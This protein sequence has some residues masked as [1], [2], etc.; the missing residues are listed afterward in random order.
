MAVWS[1][2]EGRQLVAFSL[3]C[4]LQTI[5]YTPNGLHLVGGTSDGDIYVWDAEEYGV[6]AV[7]RNHTSVVAF[8]IFSSDGHLMATGGGDK[9]CATWGA[10]RLSRSKPLCLLSAGNGVICTAAFSPDSARI[11]TGSED[12]SACI[13]NART[14]DA[15]VQIR[16]HTQ[17]IWALAFSPDGK[18]FVSG[19]GDSNICAFD[20]FT[21]ARRWS[22]GDQQG[23]IISIN[24]SPDGKLIASAA[25]LDSRINIR[26]ADDGSDFCT[27][28]NHRGN[29]TCMLYSPDGLSIASGSH[30]GSLV[31]RSFSVTDT[32]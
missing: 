18:R 24:F 21:G 2:S 30:D 5:A 4:R 6:R 17:A 7:L 13:W 27:Y 14:G 32:T 3:H 9:V 12:G 11:V 28:D 20:S 8:I 29:V 22:M 26:N 31:L 15:L 23:G 10:L 1:L 19:S 16:A 25:S